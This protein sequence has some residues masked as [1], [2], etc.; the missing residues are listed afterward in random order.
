M[1]YLASKDIWDESNPLPCVRIAFLNEAC[2]GTLYVDWEKWCEYLQEQRALKQD[3][4]QCFGDQ[5]DYE[6]TLLGADNNTIQHFIN[7]L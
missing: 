4:V 5:I 6:T 3:F 2:D 7:W 1:N